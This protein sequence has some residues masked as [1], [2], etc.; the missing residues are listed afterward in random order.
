MMKRAFQ[1]TQKVNACR[2]FSVSY[3]L[4]HDFSK[5]TSASSDEMSHFNA[6]ASSWWDVDGPQRIL[7]KMNLLRV[8]YINEVI[9]DNVKL[10]DDATNSDDEVYIAPYNL[11]LLPRSIKERILQEQDEKRAEIFAEKPLR[12]LDVGC[13]GGILSES[14]ARLNYVDSVKGID[15]SADVLEAAKLHMKNDPD[16]TDVLSYEYRAVEDLPKE[17]KYDIITVF[18]MLEHVR[19]PAEILSEVFDRLETGGFVFLSTINRDFVSWFTTIFMGEH[20][21]RIVPVGTHSLK[22]YI[23]EGEIR[24]WLLSSKYKE[25]F[26]VVDSRGCVYLPACGWKFTNNAEMGNYF[27][28]FQKIR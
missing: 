13:G 26:Q 16:L 3:L 12:V 6:L 28:A 25:K 9:K 21:L 20:I 10:N 23:N 15:L 14:L 24:Q 5:A 17:E 8:D 22:K 2:R 11:D 4:K 19:Y 18:E 1:I 27:M 7:H